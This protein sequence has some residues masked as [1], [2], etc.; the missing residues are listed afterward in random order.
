VPRTILLNAFWHNEAI[1]V[2]KKEAK[3]PDSA[4]AQ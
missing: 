3:T 1:L 2:I 4:A